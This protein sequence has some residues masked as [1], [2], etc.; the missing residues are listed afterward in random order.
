M[1]MPS[2]G[3]L[4]KM[5][6][7][8]LDALPDGPAPYYVGAKDG[9]FA[10][11]R[12]LIGRG[13]VKLPHWPENFKEAGTNSGQFIF[14]APTIPAALMGQIVDFFRRTYIRQKTE[15]AV[16]LTLHEQTKEWGVFIPTQLVS[17]GGV[18]YVYDPGHIAGGRL[19]VGSFHSHCMMGAFHS[20]TDTGD[21]A[22]FDGFHG[23]IGLIMN[24]PPQVAAMV[25]M[26][27]VNMHY[28]DEHFPTLFDMSEYDQHE[29][30]AWWDQYVGGAVQDGH[31]VGFELY[32][33]FAKSTTIKKEHQSKAVTVYQPQTGTMGKGQHGLHVVQPMSDR[34][35]ARRAMDDWGMPGWGWDNWDE[36]GT[37]IQAQKPSPKPWWHPR[38][39]E[40]MV[41][42]GYRWDGMAG[43]YKWVGR[44]E[45]EH[46]SEILT[47]SAEFNARKEAE[48]GVNWNKEDGSLQRRVVPLTE[49]SREFSHNTEDDYW[50]DLLRPKISDEAF[51][52]MF[53]ADIY[54]E[55]D[56]QWAQDH[57]E[58]CG[59][60]EFWK[61][62]TFR[63]AIAAVTVLRAFGVN[64]KLSLSKAEIEPASTDETILLPDETK[65]RHTEEPKHVVQ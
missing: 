60:L 39:H 6:S 54:T 2:F 32:A 17:S 14:D 4:I 18:N 7:G 40:Q 57:P 47:E 30:P 37:V 53:D 46:L 1:T 61:D 51:D 24:N 56:L 12:L 41:E 33:K 44:Q 58:Q 64:V 21:A 34:E 43:T 28:K 52:A 20:G 55:D 8:G 5:P 31:P 45:P 22:E 49:L 35:R 38:S 63:K 25:S 26:N 59:E 48:R 42:Q 50:E 15:A 23:T 62:L 11:R 19:V 3:E 65:P 9:L 29:A 10:H 36:R 27:K 13:I 16:L